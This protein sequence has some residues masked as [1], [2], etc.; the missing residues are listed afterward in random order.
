MEQFDEAEAVLEVTSEA[1]GAME[2]A[3]ATYTDSIEG[4]MNTLKATAQELSVGLL[5]TD[6][7][8]GATTALTGLLNV[9]NWFIDKLGAV[10]TA[11]S[12]IGITAF[13]KSVGGAK[14][15]A[16]LSAPTYVPVVTR[17]EHA[18]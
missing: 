8:K 9:L 5:D 11:V 18:A 7:V 12:A 3:Y 13:I 6:L 17:N 15:I 4:R 2:R 1:E 16:L 14:M 10:P